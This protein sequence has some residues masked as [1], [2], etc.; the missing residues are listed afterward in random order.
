MNSTIK[1]TAKP[2]IRL[3]AGRHQRLFSINSATNQ[4]LIGG[5]L[6]FPMTAD[7]I[8]ERNLI[9][10]IAKSREAAAND[11]YIKQFLK[12]CR[13]QVV[14]ST[15]IALR[16][17]SKDPSGQS[18]QWANDAIELAFKRYSSRAFCD[19][20]GKL[21]LRAIQNACITS[22]AR[23]GEF[24]IRLIKNPSINPFG[25][26]I[27]MLDPIRCPVNYHQEP[28][29][30]GHYIKQGIEFDSWG[31]PL[32]YHFTH[33]GSDNIDYNLGGQ[34]FV[35]IPADE[36]IHGFLPELTEQKRGLPWTATAL[37]RLKML[38]GMEDATL[39][40]ARASAS[41][42]GFFQWREGYGPDMDDDMEPIEEAMEPNVSRE[43]PPGLEFKEYNPNYPTG[44][45]QSFS[46][47]ILRGVASGLG[48]AY[49]HLANDLENVNFSSIRQGT[50]D[51]REFWKELQ[52]W[53]IDELM[54]PLYEHWLPAALKAGAIQVNGKPLKLE[55]LQKYLN[56][57][58]QPR[59]WDWI[60][61]RADLDAVKGRLASG[62]TSLSKVIRERGED[63]E[64][65]YEEIAQ[66]IAAMQAA[67]IPDDFI[68][69]AF[70][71]L[72]KGNKPNE[73]QSDEK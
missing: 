22:A 1:P 33:V 32:A 7:Q 58:W 61:P 43:I 62:I 40:N 68:Q 38:A 27:H 26:A 59:S 67:G 31:R 8:I 39:I 57:S 6:N 73:K 45:A 16:A 50:L 30:N 41:K 56:V 54:Q 20:Q 3:K 14:G 70:Q 25:L 2:R 46:K 29:H 28:T 53:L 23:D 49:N 47:S 71:P 17:N 52:Q 18:D 37:M 51:E 13:A 34:S 21:S 11:G 48:V 5:S 63:P 15:G 9:P 42:G 36:I 12:M 60:D 65:I 24:F 55:R 4:R 64:K 69:Y 44:E 72:N 10:L 35:R 19:V 66:D